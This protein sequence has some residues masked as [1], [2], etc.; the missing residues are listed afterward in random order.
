MSLSRVSVTSLTLGKFNSV[1]TAP[2]LWDLLV[3]LS[4]PLYGSDFLMELFL[5]III[6]TWLFRWKGY[7]RFN[8]VWPISFHYSLLYRLTRDVFW[9]KKEDRLLDYITFTIILWWVPVW[10]RWGGSGENFGM[11]HKKFRNFTVLKS[12]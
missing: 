1:I 11:M 12:F 2:D 7:D 6:T 10:G 4:L 5:T 9:T 3:N 8:Y